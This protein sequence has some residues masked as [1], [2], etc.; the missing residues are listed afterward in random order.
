MMKGGGLVKIDSR[1]FG[2]DGAAWVE[3]LR[4]HVDPLLLNREVRHLKDIS[5]YNSIALMWTIRYLCRSLRLL[6][7][8]NLF[9]VQYL[10]AFQ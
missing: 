7:I 4:V 9:T 6:K 3:N 5:V 2:R 10:E 8:E 1:A